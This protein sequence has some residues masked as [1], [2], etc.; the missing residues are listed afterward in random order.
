MQIN[1][2]CG[3]ACVDYHL[4][5]LAQLNPTLHHLN[6]LANYSNALSPNVFTVYPLI[7]FI[8]NTWF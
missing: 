2:K 8:K 1:G 5:F 4:N 7:I 3:R 6:P